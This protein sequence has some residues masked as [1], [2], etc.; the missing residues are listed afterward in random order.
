MWEQYNFRQEVYNSCNISSFT[1]AA[2][3]T[4][5]VS[6]FFRSRKHY[7]VSFE[8]QKIYKA[9][10]ADIENSYEE[11]EDDFYL[12]KKVPEDV[13]IRLRTKLAK[14]KV[15]ILKMLST[16][17]VESSNL[18]TYFR[19]GITLST[20]LATNWASSPIPEKEKLQKF[21]FPEGVTYNREKGL[22]LPIARLNCISESDKNKQGS[23][24]AAL[25]NLV[26]SAAFEPAMP[27]FR[28][29]LQPPFL[30]SSRSC[31]L[32]KQLSKCPFS[33]DSHR[34]L[35]KKRETEGFLLLKYARLCQ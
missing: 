30:V 7:E 10:L 35:P 24:S 1:Q 12:Y 33:G 28:T 20:Q 4:Y 21:V 9:Q 29:T 8:Q 32:S 6:N 19:K 23:I 17:D 11:M 25:S 5:A 26:G 22:F 13:Y 16:L 27:A 34:S 31:R 3:L 15:E 2:H 18:K 14:E